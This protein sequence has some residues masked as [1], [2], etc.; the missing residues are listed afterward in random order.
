MSDRWDEEKLELL[1]RQIAANSCCKHD[2]DLNSNRLGG[3]LVPAGHNTQELIMTTARNIATSMVQKST[4]DF[5]DENTDRLNETLKDMDDFRDQI[6]S[7]VEVLHFTTRMKKFT[8]NANDDQTLF[9]RGLNAIGTVRKALTEKLKLTC[10]PVHNIPE[11][12]VF[13][14][15][16]KIVRI[17]KPDRITAEQMFEEYKEKAARDADTI[18]TATRHDR[19]NII[20][21]MNLSEF[22]EPSQIE[23]GG[24]PEKPLNN[25]G[26]YIGRYKMLTDPEKGV[27]Y[28]PELTM[29][30][31]DSTLL[32]TSLIS[33]NC[34]ILNLLCNEPEYLKLISLIPK[35]DGERYTL[36]LFIMKS[37]RF[38]RSELRSTN[39]LSTDCSSPWNYLQ[40]WIRVAENT[41]PNDIK[42]VCTRTRQ[43]EMR[44]FP[45]MPVPTTLKTTIQQLCRMA[46]VSIELACSNY[47]TNILNLI[48]EE[49]EEH[50]QVLNFLAE[51]RFLIETAFGKQI[52]E[53]GSIISPARQAEISHCVR[54]CLM[55]DHFKDQLGELFQVTLEQK[56]NQFLIEMSSTEVFIP[57]T[58]IF[59]V[60]EKE[61]ICWRSRFGGR[62]A[63]TD[64]PIDR[65]ILNIQESRNDNS[66]E[67]QSSNESD[68][69]ST[70]EEN[71]YSEYDDSDQDDTDQDDTDQDNTDN[72][73]DN[74]YCVVCRGNDHFATNCELRTRLM[75]FHDGEYPVFDR[76]VFC[77]MNNHRTRN[78]G[79]N[80]ILEMEKGDWIQSLIDVNY[81]RLHAPYLGVYKDLEDNDAIHNLEVEQLGYRPCEWTDVP[82]ARL[83]SDETTTTDDDQTSV[84][85]TDDEN[86][87]T[88]KKDSEKIASSKDVACQLQSEDF[89]DPEEWIYPGYAGKYTGEYN[90]N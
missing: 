64:Q 48:E 13:I 87:V 57:V 36:Y 32:K 10:Q 24:Y 70:S 76:C 16:S 88:I 2:V 74:T 20:L 45:G 83:T 49:I 17:K 35:W 53:L 84:K 50:K 29:N 62:S 30:R 68:E 6:H 37:I 5:I 42:N 55:H 89:Y 78:C 38:V 56:L 31:E 46:D 65:L 66:S 58:L 77:N 26:A 19:N 12:P 3:A 51:V 71:Q 43:A 75:R 22:Y 67:C 8:H 80:K 60:I 39:M 28:E 81:K 14:P 33:K 9:D 7:G 79:L 73:P 85:E 1:E 86:A 41:L 27:S 90:A 72:S 18:S 4:K 34:T 61:I 40:T 47:Q 15:S 44:Q 25:I 23:I 63:H 59:S 52:E 82:C 21:D 69:H 54:H 11:P